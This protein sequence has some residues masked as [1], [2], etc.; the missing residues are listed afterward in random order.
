[1]VEYCLNRPGV[2]Q[3]EKNEALFAALNSNVKPE[4]TEALIAGGADVNFRDQNQDTPLILAIGKPEKFETAGKTAALSIAFRPLGPVRTRIVSA[5]LAKGADPTAK[6][7]AGDMPLTLLAAKSEPILLDSIVKKLP[8]RDVAD[9]AGKTALMVAAA[10]NN[11][12]SVDLLL[13]APGKID[14]VDNLGKTAL[15]HAAERGNVEI[16]RKLLKAGADANHKDK[17]GE[18]PLLLATKN[19]HS[20]M[21]NLL[22]SSGANA[23]LNTAE[24]KRALQNAK[25]GKN[26]ELVENLKP[27]LTKA[28]E[29]NDQVEFERLLSAGA[30]VDAQNPDG[31]TPLTRALELNHSNMA[32]ML[33][34]KGANPNARSG[35]NSSSTALILA[36]KNGDEPLVKLLLKKGAR[37]GDMDVTGKNAAYH[38]EAMALGHITKMLKEAEGR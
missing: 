14:S 5:L 2:T 6:N 4:I 25:G 33:V 34:E 23:N 20:P 32:A 8:S 35:S 13:K 21:V 10:E 29:K 30:Q 11:S 38:A 28:I 27:A 17:A 18:T 12:S 1:M 3:D 26:S 16:A 22:I 19:S 36:V 15:S 37:P 9:G 24:G 31:G 7:A